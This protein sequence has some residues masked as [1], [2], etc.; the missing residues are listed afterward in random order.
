MVAWGLVTPGSQMIVIVGWGGSATL[1][2]KEMCSCL[3]MR[4]GP[5]SEQ[6]RVLSRSGKARLRLAVEECDGLERGDLEAFAAAYV[7]AGDLIVATNHVGLSLGEAGAVTLIG[8]AWQLGALAADDPLDHV[9]AG[10]AAVR[11]IEGVFALFGGFCKKIAFFDHG[12]TFLLF[13][14]IPY[15]AVR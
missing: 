9:F 7:A 4:Q 1:S 3:R 11:A 14:S 15:S 13:E 2:G 10:L 6:I 12:P 5:D 8:V